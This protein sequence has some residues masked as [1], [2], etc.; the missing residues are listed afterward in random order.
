[1]CITECRCIKRV[2]FKDKVWSGI[3]KTSRNNKCSYLVG[4]HKNGFSLY[5]ENLPTSIL[6]I[7]LNKV[8]T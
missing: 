3:K 2:N 1:M 7:T 6:I 5:N 8:C 4:V